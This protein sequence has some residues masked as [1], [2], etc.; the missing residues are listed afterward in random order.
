[1]WGGDQVGKTLKSNI[2]ARTRSFSLADQP[3]SIR[4]AVKVTKEL[5]F[6]YLWVDSL[7]IVQDDEDDKA[8]EIGK[9]HSVY[10]NAEL[11]ISAARSKGS[12]DGFLDLCRPLA[13]VR[14]KYRGPDG[15][16]GTVIAN[17]KIYHI[18]EPAEPIHGRGWTLQEHLLSKRLLIFGTFGLRWVCQ[19]GSYLDGVQENA[20]GT[21]TEIS[22]QV[23]GRGNPAISMQWGD[24]VDAFT[25][26]ALTDYKDRLP[27]I[28]AIAA[29]YAAKR[30]PGPY[31]AGLWTDSLHD[32]LLWQVS[33]DEV[34]SSRDQHSG[35]PT[36]SWAS[37]SRPIEYGDYTLHNRVTVVTLEFVSA[38][39]VPMFTGAPFAQVK[40]GSLRVKGHLAPVQCRA[41]GLDATA[42]LFEHTEYSPPLW[43]WAHSRCV[44]RVAIFDPVPSVTG[45]SISDIP[46]NSRPCAGAILDSIASA[47]DIGQ[48]F[49]FEVYGL[50][51]GHQQNYRIHD[52]L[53]R[54]EEMSE[55]EESEYESGEDDT[56]LYSIGLVLKAVDQKNN[57]FQRIGLYLVE[58]PNNEE[59]DHL[60]ESPQRP[61]LEDW[62]RSCDK[63]TV[64]IV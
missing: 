28:S 41:V 37:M 26:R 10:Q 25:S 51:P 17:L 53:P 44:H 59:S 56:Q 27:A 38:H 45:M 21:K 64:D 36:W 11:T 48:C 58:E 13:S 50:V 9:M 61:Y 12:K 54:N 46:P 52:R 47:E 57:V 23:S 24:L 14:F 20:S 43:R 39:V 30:K 34:D 42:N 49:C 2:D 15:T 33:D 19:G 4:D 60:P 22:E 6:E 31:L 32:D 7:C 18:S 35:F 29:S 55:S 3:K 8:Q 1:M 63:V 16:L 62:I 5:G 40:Q